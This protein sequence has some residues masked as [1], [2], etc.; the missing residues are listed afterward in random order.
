[1]MA[2][3]LNMK[4]YFAVS[5][6]IRIL[7]LQLLHRT[8]YGLFLNTTLDSC[9]VA[10]YGHVSLQPN[11]SSPFLRHITTVP[12]FSPFSFF[13]FLLVMYASSFISVTP[14]G[15][16]IFT[17]HSP[18][19]SRT[20]HLIKTPSSIFSTPKSSSFTAASSSPNPAPSTSVGAVSP[21]KI[22]LPI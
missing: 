6:S 17:R 10:Q 8:R 15:S 2:L 19:Q 4:R 11:S 7:L 22:I 16:F 1:M 21:P 14:S 9:S 3:I 12:V 20:C 5:F 18:S 13:N